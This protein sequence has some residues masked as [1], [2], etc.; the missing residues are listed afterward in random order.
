MIEPVEATHSGTRPRRATA[1]GNIHLLPER[2]AISGAL[3][4]SAQLVDDEGRV[5]QFCPTGR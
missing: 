1:D 2:P 5:L 4:F 3:R